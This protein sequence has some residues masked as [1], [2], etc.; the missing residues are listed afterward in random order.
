MH[1]H[2]GLNKDVIGAQNVGRQFVPFVIV[3]AARIELHNAISFVRGP[4]SQMN[5]SA[6]YAVLLNQ[7][8]DVLH[9]LMGFVLLQRGML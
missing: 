2:T 9:K 6:G 7:F 8:C 3:H 1:E 4:A 5:D